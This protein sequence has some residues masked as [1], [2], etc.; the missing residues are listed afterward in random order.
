MKDLYPDRGLVRKPLPCGLVIDVID[1]GP[2]GIESEVIRPVSV[3]DL[4]APEGLEDRV[5]F[6]VGIES[7]ALIVHP[8]HDP[9]RSWLDAVPQKWCRQDRAPSS[10]RARMPL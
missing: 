5:G 10:R 6:L 8:G 1:L 4:P 7:P 9:P 3:N 2:H